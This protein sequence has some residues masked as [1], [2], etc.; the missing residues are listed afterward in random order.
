MNHF[1]VLIQ[2]CK[3]TIILFFLKAILSWMIV[4]SQ[5]QGFHTLFTQ[6]LP[7]I[8]SQRIIIVVQYQI[9]ET[10][11]DIIHW[12]SRFHQFYMYSLYIQ[13]QATLPCL[14]LCDHHWCMMYFYISFQFEAQPFLN[15]G[16]FHFLWTKI[17][18]GKLS[19]V[20]FSR[21]TAP[22]H[23]PLAHGFLFLFLVISSLDII[24][25]WTN[26]LTGSWRGKYGKRR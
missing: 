17:C 26:F 11:I 19:L 8:K 12:S 4:K 14:D 1:A 25:F 21:G 9:Q 15:H 6:F 24:C 3:S 5:I 10:D 7:V 16:D 23:P 2:H 20:S 13:F 22:T 18:S